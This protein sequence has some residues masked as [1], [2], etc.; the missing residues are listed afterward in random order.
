M[1][2][3]QEAWERVEA[4]ISCNDGRHLFPV[5]SMVERDGVLGKVLSSNALYAV[6]RW[7]DL[8]ETIEH[9]DRSVVC[10]GRP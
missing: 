5:Q 4:F 1:K 10:L 8:I 2:G 9:G 3:S 7:P 6:I